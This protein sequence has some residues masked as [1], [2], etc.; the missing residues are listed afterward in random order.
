[1]T[2]HHNLNKSIDVELHKPLS[3]TR[4]FFS[5]GLTFLAFA[6]T[7]IAL[8]P[9]FAILYKIVAEGFGHLSWEVLVSLPA[10]VGVEDQPNGFAN[11]IV[12]TFIM[13]GIATLFSLPIGVMTGIFLA[14][15]TRDH[16]I[17]AHIIRFI[18]VILSSVPSIVVG[19]FA[20]ALIVVST[21]TFSAL[22]GGFALSIIMLP[23]V[24]LTTEEALKLVPTS[25]R[26]ASAALGGGRFQSMFR[27]IIPSA[28]PTIVTGILLAAAR[29]A[30]E[31]APLIVTALSSQFWSEDL[32]SP[33]ASMSVLIYSYASSP[34]K[35]QNELAWTAAAV[36]LG[37]VLLSS[38]ISRLVTRK[39]LKLR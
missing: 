3:L 23:M 18:T 4:N 26:L 21:K 34:Y 29:A 15:F 27:V 33:T 25:Y 5:Q 14:E 28:L 7:A 32:L 16:K 17:I 10:P 30:G 11:A 2:N 24:A 22:A 1:M 38:I 31:T 37:M 8:M 6:L 39:Q 36:L 19:V 13:V 9:L 12:G 35:E 20:Y